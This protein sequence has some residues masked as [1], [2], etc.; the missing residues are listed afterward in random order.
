MGHRKII[1]RSPRSFNSFKTKAS[2]DWRKGIL[3]KPKTLKKFKDVGGK[4]EQWRQKYNLG[5]KYKKPQWFIT[6]NKPPLLK[7]LFDK[8]SIDQKATWFDRV[9]KRF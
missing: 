8:R 7:P 4:R 2:Y 6:K 1:I 9:I 5:L 3:N